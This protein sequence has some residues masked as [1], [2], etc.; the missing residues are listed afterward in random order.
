MKK[1][2]LN[3]LKFLL[4]AEAS[5]DIIEVSVGGLAS[6][7]FNMFKNPS[8]EM[9]WSFQAARF[10]LSLGWDVDLSGDMYSGT[11]STSPF[12]H[13]K[14]RGVNEVLYLH[15]HEFSGR[16]RESTF[17]WLLH[18]VNKWD[19]FDVDP[20][21]VCITDRICHVDDWKSFVSKH[22]SAYR[23]AALEFFQARQQFSFVH[24]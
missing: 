23:A 6:T 7:Y 4:Q 22:E 14:F 15:P 5:T 3:C 18:E 8:E 2:N 12:A 24:K 19:G 10:F 20:K 13:K 11:F 16:I 17:W 21:R 9:E 1:I